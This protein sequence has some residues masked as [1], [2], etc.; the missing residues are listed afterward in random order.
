MEPKVG[1]SFL[2]MLE[3]L[4]EPYSVL[5][6]RARLRGFV[7]T[8]RSVCHTWRDENGDGL[9]MFD[10]SNYADPPCVRTTLRKASWKDGPCKLTPTEG[11][12]ASYL[13]IVRDLLGIEPKYFFDNHHPEIARAAVEHI[14]MR[15]NDV[16]R[17]VAHYGDKMLHLLSPS[18]SQVALYA[19]L[20]NPEGTRPSQPA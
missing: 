13:S 8:L 12:T 9:F 3:D 19:R 5:P 14:G 16:P 20:R 7:G 15:V 18:V 11:E 4:V 2:Y 10:G 6:P 17:T 1:V